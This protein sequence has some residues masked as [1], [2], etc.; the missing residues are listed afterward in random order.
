MQR[1][2]IEKEKKINSPKYTRLQRKTQCL[3]SLHKK[4]K[5]QEQVHWKDVN[6][7][8]RV[9]TGMFKVIFRCRLLCNE[10][11]NLRNLY[12]RLLE[13]RSLGRVL[14]KRQR[15]FSSSWWI[16]SPDIIH[17][18]LTQT[19]QT[20]STPSLC[21]HTHTNIHLNQHTSAVFYFF[22]YYYIFILL[23]LKEFKK[24]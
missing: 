4:K 12:T 2:D 19:V 24:S 20:S 11:S 1:K 13:C 15:L 23:M 8:L 9:E 6:K 18:S 22:F 17:N 21:I 5:K 10:Y 3:F 7:E 14:R 16:L